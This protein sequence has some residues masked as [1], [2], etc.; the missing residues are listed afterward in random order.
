MSFQSVEGLLQAAR[1]LPLWEA[2]LEH[3]CREEGISREDSLSR[4]TA[5][6]QAMKAAVADYDPARRSASG[7]VGGAAARVESSPRP[8]VG[9]FVSQVIAA[10]LK[11][12][13]CNACMRRIVAAPTAGASGVLPAVLLPYQDKYHTPDGEMV[14]ALYAAA[15]IILLQQLDSAVIVPKLVGNK[16]KLHPVLV[17]LSLSVFGSVFGIWGM[18][19]A[20]PV[21]A[22]IKIV[23]S[24]IYKAK[25]NRLT[26]DLEI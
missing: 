14:E 12:G 2:V 16:V 1:E 21:T 23:F 22:L 10:A 5:L 24:R 11:T 6:W 15:A 18:V 20:V 4:M 25:R 7:L 26:K 17:I 13:E 19:F 8:I 9:G 3:D